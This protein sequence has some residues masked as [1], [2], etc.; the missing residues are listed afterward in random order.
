MPQKPII[1]D[2]KQVIGLENIITSIEDRIVY[3]YDAIAPADDQI[4]LCVVL[5]GNRDEI[6]AI[7]ALANAHQIPVVPRGAGTGLVGASVPLPGSNVL[8]TTRL[9]RILEIDPSNLTVLVEPGVV[10]DVLAQAV[11][12]QGLFYPPDPG[13]IA[14]STLGGNIASMPVGCAASNTVSLKIL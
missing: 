14:V 8:L 6:S 5:P 12:A 11:A 3:A 4:P 9:N 2:L 13:S 10:T 1:Q 7:L